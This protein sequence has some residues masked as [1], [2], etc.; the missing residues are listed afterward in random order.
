[1]KYTYLILALALMVG[2]TKLEPKFY[3]DLTT[4][5]AYSS[6]SD[7]NAALVGVYADLAPF[8]GDG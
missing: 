2:C 4:G 5:N 1:M 3:T 7:I 8:P 6:E